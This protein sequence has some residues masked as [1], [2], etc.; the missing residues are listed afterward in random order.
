MIQKEKVLN[1]IVCYIFL[2]YG[3]NGASD[4]KLNLE[5]K[6]AY[7]VFDLLAQFW[8]FFS[9]FCLKRKIFTFRIYL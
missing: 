2:W 1:I 9:R 7:R 5:G 4:K 6:F 8:G 3:V